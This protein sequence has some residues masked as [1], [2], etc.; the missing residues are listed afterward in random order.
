MNFKNQYRLG[1]GLLLFLFISLI[2][3]TE[4]FFLW[5][6]KIF[7]IQINVTVKIPTIPREFFRGI[8]ISRLSSEKSL[9]LALGTNTVDMAYAPSWRPRPGSDKVPISGKFLHV[10]WID[11]WNILWDDPFYLNRK[12]NGIAS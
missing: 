11:S 10:A 6:K 3:S 4:H 2:V 9:V 7:L 12:K 5:D 1:V 8:A